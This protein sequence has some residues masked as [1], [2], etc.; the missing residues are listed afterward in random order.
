MYWHEGPMVCYWTCYYR[1][2]GINYLTTQ[3]FGYI[4]LP[5]P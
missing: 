3:H 4:V 1:R 5:C 2:S